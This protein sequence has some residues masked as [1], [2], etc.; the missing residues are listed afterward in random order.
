[1]KFI[2]YIHRIILLIPL[3]TLVFSQ[4]LYLEENNDGDWNVK[5]VSQYDI[6]SF[7]FTVEGASVDSANGGAVETAGFDIDPDGLLESRVI[8][9]S[10]S[11]AFIPATAGF[12]ELLIILYVKYV[13]NV[14]C[15]ISTTVNIL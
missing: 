6:S 3:V 4:E 8:S 13:I 15:V 5:Y 14:L 2:Q 7:A 11:E 10:S 1:M 12:P 9:S